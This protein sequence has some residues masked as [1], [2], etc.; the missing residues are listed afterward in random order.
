MEVKD[1][2]QKQRDRLIFLNHIPNDRK[3]DAQWEEYLKF[4][5]MM[6]WEEPG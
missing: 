4:Y 1:L 5:E 6:D 2:T 3:T